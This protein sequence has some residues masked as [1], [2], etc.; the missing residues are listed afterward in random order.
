MKDEARILGSIPEGSRLVALS[1]AGEAVDI[2]GVGRVDRALGDGRTGR[3][4]FAIGGA[5]ALPAAVLDR[6]ESTWASRR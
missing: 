2:A 5:D 1:R 3:R 6:A 4:A